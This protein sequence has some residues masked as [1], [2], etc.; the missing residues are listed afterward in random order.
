MARGEIISGCTKKETTHC[1]Q[2]QWAI[3]MK[4][5]TL[6][7]IICTERE[8]VRERAVADPGFEQRGSARMHIRAFL[9]DFDL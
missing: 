5:C 3:E 6:N 4:R 8:R 9:V 2:Y 7:I 1:Q